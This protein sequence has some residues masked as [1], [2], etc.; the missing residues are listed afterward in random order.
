MITTYVS[1]LD[2]L[3]F[4][5]RNVKTKGKMQYNMLEAMLDLMKQ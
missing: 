4:F 1:I 5:P 2:M 3:L